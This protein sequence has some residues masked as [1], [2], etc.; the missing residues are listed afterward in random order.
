MRYNII[1]VRIEFAILVKRGIFFKRNF[2]AVYYLGV[3]LAYITQMPRL[4]FDT[5]KL[6]ASH[7]ITYD[8][9]GLI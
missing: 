8:K 5:R 2:T 6:F 7:R 1:S 4:I 9:P 3:R